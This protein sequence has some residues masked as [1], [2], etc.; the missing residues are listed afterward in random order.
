MRV[1]HVI[2]DENIGGAG[3][4]LCSLLRN[5]DPTC[6][7]SIIA[8]PCGSALVARLS[9]LEIPLVELSACPDRPKGRAV[10]ELCRVIREQKPA[11]V[12]TNASMAARVAAR[13]CRVPVI[14]TRHCCFPPEGVLKSPPVARIAGGINRALSDHVIAPAEA[15]AEDLLRLGIPHER[16]TVIK[17]G[18][19]ELRTPTASEL[20][21]ARGMWGLSPDD[22]V[23]GICARLVACKDH[24]TFLRAARIC[25]DHTPARCLRFLIVGEGEE[26]TRLERLTR[27]LG[28]SSNVTLTGFVSDMATVYPLLNLNVNCSVGTETSCLALS[29]GMSAGVP[30][31][32]SDYGGNPAMIGESL[33]GVV[34]PMRDAERLASLIL[35]IC[36]DPV[37]ERKMR[38]AARARY[39]QCYT[40]RA[41]AREVE[42]VYREVLS[43]TE[44][45]APWG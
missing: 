42:G 19:E 9:P 32:V 34:F 10:R 17:N 11:L 14:H 39:L 41:M 28:L 26:R 15:A 12:H 21:A 22:F 29:E 20:S 36:A 8:L 25:L 43:K 30:V 33:A 27:E 13:I 31:L 24:E 5:F 4:L 16:I 6:V 1:L 35:R 40:A 3:V 45:S 38:S 37:M 2:S 44:K 7:E 18:S 23:V